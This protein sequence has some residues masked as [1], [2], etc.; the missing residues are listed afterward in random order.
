MSTSK[1]KYVKRILVHTCNEILITLYNDMLI[2]MT[3]RIDLEH[4]MPSEISFT[5]NITC[6]LI[7]LKQNIPT[8]Q[9]HRVR[10]Q[11]SGCQ[12]LGARGY[13]EWLLNGNG[14]FFY[15]DETVLKLEMVVAQHCKYT[16][17]HGIIHFKRAVCYVNFTSIKHTHAFTN[18]CT[19]TWI[20]LSS[21][22]LSFIYF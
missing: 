11:I 4:I 14:A 13:R 19:K 1:C 22:V 10:K 20:R 12:G 21:S 18:T 16:K 5:Q 2:N 6:C 9:I 3:V 8:R 7:S 15:R 17:C